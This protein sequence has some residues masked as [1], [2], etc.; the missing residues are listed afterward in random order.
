MAAALAVLVAMSG[1][2]S[3]GPTPVAASTWSLTPLCAGVNVRTQPASTAARK[4]ALS[5]G[6][7]VVA[8]ATVAGAAYASL[9]GGVTRKGSTWYRITSI[10]GKSVKTLYG[11]T[12]LYAAAGLFKVVSVST[13]LYARCDGVVARS[14]AATTALKKVTLASGAKVVSNGSVAGGKWT[15]G[16]GT[17]TTGTSWYRIVSINGKSVKTLYGVTYLYVARVLLATA[18]PVAPS[19]SPSPSPS[20]TP[21]PSPTAIASASASVVPTPTPTPRPRPTPICRGLM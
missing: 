10:N 3:G 20:P 5:A 21:T 14:S 17:S 7:K 16:C 6:A 8:I 11:V 4:V 15:A 12:Y 2:W 18:P 1:V 9:C 19:P 13:T